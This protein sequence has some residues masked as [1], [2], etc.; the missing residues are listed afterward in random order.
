[1][2][3][4]RITPLSWVD[5]DPDYANRV[6]Y[7]ADFLGTRVPAPKLAEALRPSATVE[8][9][10]YE[11]FTVLLHP[12]RKLAFWT[13]VNID[14][15]S[16][17]RLGDRSRDVWW[18][19]DRITP[20]KTHQTGNEFYT[21]SGFQ[22]GHLVRRLDPAWGRSDKIAAR[23][24]ADS[25]HWANCSP[26]IP[27]LNTQW[28]LAVET[29][30]LNTVNANNS[31]VT[32]FSG[33]LF[34]KH[35]PLYRSLRIPL[36][37]WKVLA[38]T[39]GRTRTLR[40]LG[41]F[42]K[43]DEAV[44]ALLRKRGALKRDIAPLAVDLDDVPTKIQGYQMTVAELETRTQLSFGRLAR[45]DVDVYAAKRKQRLAPLAFDSVDIYRRLRS[46]RDLITE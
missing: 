18:Y 16:E 34:T 25:F 4:Q 35:D 13:A 10:L 37:Y 24:E 19:D 44:A 29:H 39:V 2:A 14:G 36:A 15:R 40:S 8:P 21:G 28:W 11:H 46:V 23:G 42:V 17:R 33:C 1:M 32:V 38:W 20:A 45:A 9:L 5:L 26:Q 22:R 6:G 27:K 12:K 41:F 30:V 31:K 3:T 43:Q 7:D